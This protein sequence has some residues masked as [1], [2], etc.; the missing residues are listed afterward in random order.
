MED[1]GEYYSVWYSKGNVEK[2]D[3]YVAFTSVR[4]N[5]IKQNKLKE[6]ISFI[7]L[8]WQSTDS[9]RFTEPLETY[10]INTKQIVLFKFFWKTIIIERITNLFTSLHELNKQANRIS[11]YEISKLDIG[12]FYISSKDANKDLTKLVAFHRQL[13]LVGL[14][15]M[16]NGLVQAQE[17][18]EAAKIQLIIEDIEQLNA[19]SLD[20]I[21]YLSKKD[22]TTI[23]AS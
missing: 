1:I 3:P 4:D 22:Q 15:R 13:T 9:S 7:H 6:L 10:L 8:S 17:I 11:A 16:K 14:V 2:I 23:F 21:D 19:P 20:C 12:N 18:N 5:W